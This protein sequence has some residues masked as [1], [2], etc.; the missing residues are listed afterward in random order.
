MQPH[1]LCANSNSMNAN[2]G[3]FNP[4]QAAGLGIL[5]TLAAPVDFAHSVQDPEKT[6]KLMDDLKKTLK[7]EDVAP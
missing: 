1:K 3:V 4:S 6:R 7:G 2:K 5:C